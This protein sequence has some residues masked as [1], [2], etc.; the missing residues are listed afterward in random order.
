[1]P[2]T[3]QYTSSI[4]YLIC[5]SCTRYDMR[6][7]LLIF[8]L[9][10][11]PVADSLAVTIDVYTGEVVVE[12]KDAKERS[13][14]LPRALENVLQK[15]SGLRSFEDQPLVE[16]TL[17]QAPSILVS[18]YY[19]NVEATLNDE[20]SGQELR[21]VAKFSA[22]AVDE[23]VR[24]LG[25]PLWPVD[26]EP[27]QIWVVV[28]DGLDRRILPVEFDYAWQSMAGVAARRGLPV[29][30]PAPDVE[31][32]FSIDAQLLWGG[33]TEDLGLAPGTGVMIM[34]ARREGAEWGVR[35]NLAYG[36]QSW[37]W[38]VQD[39]DLQAALN[40]GL[41]QAVDQVAAAKTI[42][43]A[44]LGISMYDLTIKGLRNAGDY[45]HCLSYLQGLGVVTDVAVI[46]A[47]PGRVT[48]RLQL[49]A[50][51]RYL[52][53]SLRGGQYLDFDENERLYFLSQ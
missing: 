47:Q 23:M 15:I 28:D 53:E 30:W 18:F 34:A 17:G 31:G 10:A 25:L 41:E 22:S 43:A 29:N 12:S 2:V 38:R 37:S 19:Q 39:I 8:L 44:D 36:D 51:P 21:L 42:A 40:A 5:W 35:S 33:Y 9:T 49:S 14:A 52:E 4:C 32:N 13:K 24:E 46:S 16:P 7:I 45:V 1:L 26:R 50:L 11:L 27:I 48:F 6:T 3:T 20:R